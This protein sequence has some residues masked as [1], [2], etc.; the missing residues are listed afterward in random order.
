MAKSK[1]ALSSFLTAVAY[2]AIGVLFIIKQAALIDWIMIVAGALF[3]LQGLFDIIKNKETITGIVKIIIGAA[4]ILCGVI[5]ALSAYA[6]IALGV[7]LILN[8]IM[9]FF[10]SPKNIF[11]ILAFVLTVI[12]GLALVAPQLFGF[13]LPWIFYIIG[14]VLIVNGLVLLFDKK[15]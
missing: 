7:L 8:A 6:L 2:I 4:L 15:K 9:T 14:G 3:I 13:S 5:P 10:S 11:T 1:S 12:V